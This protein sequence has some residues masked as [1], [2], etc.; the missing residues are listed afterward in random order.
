MFLHVFE[1]V[2]KYFYFNVKEKCIICQEQDKTK[3]LTFLETDWAYHAYAIADLSEPFFS[4]CQWWATE[5][6]L[7]IVSL[8]LLF[9]GLNPPILFTMGTDIHIADI[10]NRME[11]PE[12]VMLLG[13]ENH[14]PI[15]LTYYQPDYL[16]SMFRMVLTADNFCPVYHT[17]SKRSGSILL[18]EHYLSDLEQLYKNDTGNSFVAYQLRQGVFYGIFNNEVL[19]SAAGTHIISN[20]YRIAA[21][22]NITTHP[23][24]RKHGYAQ[25][26]TSAVCHD[27]LM[28]KFRLVLN[29]RQNNRPAIH[30]YK[31]LGFHVHAPFFE[32]I[33]TLQGKVRSFP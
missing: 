2:L 21:I 14:I 4:Q 24:H 22:G 23:D 25:Q 32:G 5:D 3:L 28:Q 18:D 27:L 33:A 11:L 16:D 12:R 10:L 9:M 6:E 20:D 17:P 7:G 8:V 29:V 1:D 15:I 30:M 13:S 31:K 19:I 26:V